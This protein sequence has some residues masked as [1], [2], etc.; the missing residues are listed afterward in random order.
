MIEGGDQLGSGNDMARIL[1]VVL[2]PAIDIACTAE[3]VEPQHK[4]RTRDQLHH[5]GGGGAN[6]A[7][8]LAELGSDVALAYL[9]GGETGPLYEALLSQRALREHRFAMNGPVRIS[10]TVQESASG[11]EYRFVPDG[12]QVT[13]AEVQPLL[14]FVASFDG[15]Y[16][17]AS[18]SLPPGADP[19]AYAS[20]SQMAR[21]AGTKFVLDTSGDA[22]RLALEEGGI[23]LVKPSQRELEQIAGRKLDA[24]GLAAQA[25]ALVAHGAARH[26]A[27]SMGHEGALLANEGGVFRLPA[28]KVEAKSAVGAGDSF[29]G[30]MVHW[31]ATGHDVKDAF[32]FAL[33]AG[34]AAVLHPGTELC[35]RGDVMRMYEAMERA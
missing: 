22:L 26:V 17:I 12:P 32:R 2:N 1:S 3:T 35:R 13:S 20:M 34:A 30:G 9:S 33:A 19:A 6:V 14:D 27:V 4:V 23:Y 11:K 18:G 16:L 25:S 10:Y 15:D 28:I 29:V 24:E 21:R 31:L 5:A 7:R 8:V